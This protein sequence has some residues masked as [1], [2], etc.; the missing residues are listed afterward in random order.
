MIHRTWPHLRALLIAL[1]IFAVTALAIPAPQGG[2][3][4]QAWSDPTV[5][6][7]FTAWAERL[8][9]AGSPTTTEELEEW[10]WDFAVNYMQKRKAIIGPMNPYYRYCGTYQ[11]WRMFIAP[12]RNPAILHI[13]VF[14]AD[15]WRPIYVARDLEHRWMANKFDSERFRAALFRYAWKQYR[16][17]Y[18]QF[19]TWVAKKLAVERPE[20]ERV[21]LRWY[22]FHTISPERIRAGERHEGSFVQTLSMS[23]DEHREATP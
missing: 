15:Q 17:T 9:A 22:R 4:R 16:G 7:E 19:A 13:E 18:R 21:R 6:A 12:H 23:L 1:H 2:M 11:S 3:N 14:E 8:T 5:Q 20:A 10:V